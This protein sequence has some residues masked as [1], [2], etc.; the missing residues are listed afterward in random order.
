MVEYH[1]NYVKSIELDGNTF[2]STN[3]TKLG[4]Y[5]LIVITTAHSYI[6]YRKILKESQLIL[7]TR[8]ATKNFP[9]K[10]NV[11]LL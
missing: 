11:V 3:L 1:D 10:D 7:D 9:N 8:N 2:K 4:L 6:N 5:D